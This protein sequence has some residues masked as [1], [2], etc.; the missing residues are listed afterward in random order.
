MSI[1]YNQLGNSHRSWAVHYDSTE[2]EKRR[3]KAGKALEDA[4]DIAERRASLNGS[5]ER[6]AIR[7][8]LSRKSPGKSICGGLSHFVGIKDGYHTSPRGK[9]TQPASQG[10][11]EECSGA[12]GDDDDPAKM[13]DWWRKSDSANL[14]RKLDSAIADEATSRPTFR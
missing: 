12:D 3:I 9:A 4:V 11:S 8:K 6:S 1:S 2:W 7:R 13:K 5:S 10:V 14:N